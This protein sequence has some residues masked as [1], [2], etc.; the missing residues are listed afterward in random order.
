ME[1]NYSI[2]EK[3]RYPFTTYP[4]SYEKVSPYIQ[5]ISPHLEVFKRI[6]F[7]FYHKKMEGK[8]F[9]YKSAGKYKDEIVL[10]YVGE[11]GNRKIYIGYLLQVVIKKGKVVKIYIDKLPLE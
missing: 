7:H 6:V 3:G 1:G 8:E 11:D 10:R 4:L 2:V 9:H 5:K